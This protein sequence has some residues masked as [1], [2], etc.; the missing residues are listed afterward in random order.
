MFQSD[1]VPLQESVQP[2]SF[3]NV[4]ALASTNEPPAVALQSYMQNSKML[5]DALKASTATP[6][7]ILK[8]SQNIG[9]QKSSAGAEIEC[10][11]NNA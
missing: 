6:K 10:G 2:Y 3:S 1:Y 9:D 8:A 11:E 5:M 4:G 7:S